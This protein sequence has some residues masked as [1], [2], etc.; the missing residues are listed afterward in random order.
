M[1][2]YLKVNISIFWTPCYANMLDFGCVKIEKC[3]CL[4]Y[5]LL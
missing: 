5:S 3:L 4:L 1:I 2:I